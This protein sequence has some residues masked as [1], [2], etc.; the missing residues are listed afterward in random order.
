MEAGGLSEAAQARIAVIGIGN[1]I[2]GDD[3]AGIHVARRLAR[4]FAAEP[5]VYV[6]PW[7]GDL[8]GLADVLPR[9]ERFLFVDAAVG[10][11]PGEVRRFDRGSAFFAPSFHQLDAGTVL[12]ALEALGTVAPFPP[13]ELWGI[14]ARLP[15]EF[16]EELS[17]EVGEAVARVAAALE[18]RIAATLAEEGP[19]PRDPQRR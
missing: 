13:W 14:T 3:G 1:P 9:A 6:A 18:R 2:A 11:R 15:C 8:F 17:P 10:E 12:R 16:G 4:A 19:P 7:E 5:R